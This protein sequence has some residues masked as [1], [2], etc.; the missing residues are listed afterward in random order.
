MQVP[1]PFEFLI[2]CLA[3]FRLSL[4][5]SKEDGPA[6]IFRKL[7]R[8]VPARSSAKEGIHCIFCVSVWMAIPVSIFAFFHANWAPWLQTAGDWFCLMLALSTVAIVI[9]QAFTKGAP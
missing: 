1:P 4:L 8:S 2:Y 9:N 7:R 3:V 6:W 5:V